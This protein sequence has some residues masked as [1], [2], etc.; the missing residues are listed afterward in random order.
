MAHHVRAVRRGLS[1][2][3][4]LADMPFLSYQVNAD[5]AVRNAGR[6][7][8]SGANAVKIE[9]TAATSTTITRLS[10]AGIPVMAHVGFRPQ[11]V[12]RTGVARQGKDADGAEQVIADAVAAQDAGAFAVLLELIPSDL[13]KRVT[14]SVN[15]PTIGI[16]AGPHCSGQVLVFGDLVGLR[17]DRPVFSH[18]RS[19]TQVGKQIVDALRAYKSDVESGQF[20]P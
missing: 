14:E 17:T 6:L 19:Y 5:E 2:A 13:A 4:L 8:Q 20:P 15:V 10:D 11:S 9:T 3:L 7:I 16:G 18:A 12:N 1:R